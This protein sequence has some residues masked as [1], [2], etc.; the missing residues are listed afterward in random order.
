MTETRNHMPQ[1]HPDR[2]RVEFNENQQPK[3]YFDKLCHEAVNIERRADGS[4]WQHIAEGV[5]SPYTDQSE[6]KEFSQLR[7]RIVFGKPEQQ[8]YELTVNLLN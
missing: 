7:Y 1:E 8:S 3:L 2:V 6:L 5:R 4:D